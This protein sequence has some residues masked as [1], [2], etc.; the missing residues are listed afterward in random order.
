MIKKS[1]NF[2]LLNN[3]S[4]KYYQMCATFAQHVSKTPFRG[5]PHS[6]KDVPKATNFIHSKQ[7]KT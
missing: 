1:G 4:I 6:Y 5:M 2:F 7:L 3:N